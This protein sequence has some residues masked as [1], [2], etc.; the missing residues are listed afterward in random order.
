MEHIPAENLSLA[1]SKMNSVLK[2]DGIMYHHCPNYTVP[3]EPHYG[4]PLVPFFPH[5]TGKLKGVYKEGVWQSLNFITVNKVRDIVKNLGL[6]V[7]FKK[8]M[9]QESF[10]RL[11]KDPQF[12]SR[13]PMLTKMYKGMKAVGIIN[14]MGHIPPSLCTP[15]T[16]TISKK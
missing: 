8:A 6:K 14:L 16:F 12:A 2:D 15:M 5:A 9:M 7:D 11:E 3:F 4:L 1:V 13:H 10:M